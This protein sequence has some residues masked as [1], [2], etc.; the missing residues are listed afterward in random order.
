MIIAGKNI[1]LGKVVEDQVHYGLSGA[2]YLELKFALSQFIA[3]GNTIILSEDKAI[4]SERLQTIM[5]GFSTFSGQVI[6]TSTHKPSTIPDN[7]IL[8]ELE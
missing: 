1:D 2:E 5:E 4:D 3:E 6:L 8:I 7:W